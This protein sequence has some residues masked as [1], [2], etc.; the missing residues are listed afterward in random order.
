MNISELM[1]KDLGIDEED[2]IQAISMSSMD[3]C[4]L[5]LDDEIEVSLPVDSYLQ[6]EHLEKRKQDD[7]TY[8][9]IIKD[10]NEII[11]K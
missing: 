2:Q 1:M 3:K 10:I 6:G 11:V 8:S 9:L 5:V 4:K 7:G